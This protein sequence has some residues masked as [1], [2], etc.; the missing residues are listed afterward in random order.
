MRKRTLA[1]LCSILAIVI[2]IAL[3]FRGVTV[4]L[5]LYPFAIFLVLVPLLMIP[6]T[7][8]NQRLLAWRKA[9]GRD[10]ED[11]E[12]YEIGEAEIISLR[13]RVKNPSAPG[14]QGQYL[15]ILFK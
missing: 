3:R 12:R 6:L 10:I 9:R 15:P 1:G 7:L 4:E 13:P 11:E 2:L 5:G 14:D 8:L